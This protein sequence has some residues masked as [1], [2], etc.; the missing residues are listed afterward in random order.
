[1]LSNNEFNLVTNF[2]LGLSSVTV[3]NWDIA[4][5][6]KISANSETKNCKSSFVRTFALFIRFK[7]F[8]KPIKS[9]DNAS[10]ILGWKVIFLL[11]NSVIRI[12]LLFIKCKNFANINKKII[13]NA[14]SINVFV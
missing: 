3:L 10:G 7:N 5:F 2:I 1:M 12:F 4:R 9:Q 13:N 6:I 8:S 14:S 11:V